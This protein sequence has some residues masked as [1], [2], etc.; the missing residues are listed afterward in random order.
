MDWGLQSAEFRALPGTLEENL[1]GAGEKD[2][3][4]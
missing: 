1:L 3:K 2:E 4:F